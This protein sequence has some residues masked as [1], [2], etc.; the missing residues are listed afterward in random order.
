VFLFYEA[1]ADDAASEAR[2]K[3]PRLTEFRERREREELT[4]EPVEVEIFAR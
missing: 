3:A 4:E 1:Y 2:R